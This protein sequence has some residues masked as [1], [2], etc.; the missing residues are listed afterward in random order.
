MKLLIDIGHPAHVHYFRNAATHFIAG[1][2]KVLFTTRDKEVAIALLNFY[3]F[4][5]VNFGRPY[6]TITGKMLGLLLFNYKLLQ[7]AIKFKPDILLSAGSIYAAHV[8]FLIRRHHITLE[9]TFNMEQVRLYLP[10]TSAVLTGACEHISLGS[11]EIRYDSYQEMA[12]LHPK[13]F[14]PD[15]KILDELG[16]QKNE[17]F[18]I[19]RFVSWNASHD[20][21]HGGLNME[22]K[23]ELIGLLSTYGKVFISSEKSLDPE[24][25]KY[26]YPLSPNKMHDALA[27]AD[28]FIGEGATMASECVMLGTPA[29]Y[30]NSIVTHTINEQEKYGLIWHYRCGDGVL[31]KTMELLADQ[32]L[33]VKSQM[34]HKNLLSEK[35]D[36]TA[37]LIWFIENWPESCK[38][39]KN[40]PAIQ[41]RFK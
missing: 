29:I 22:Q 16:I 28:L 38:I 32:Q 12:Y 40:N 5:Y 20:A 18:F 25:E 4:D 17:A 14:T 41:E 26:R 35:I 2:H 21:G 11:K 15:R 36:L 23:R 9:D 27:F 3:R 6:K 30:V 10:F 37:F 1:G 33:K 24:F 8:S 34:G 13:Y 19:L 39:A 7:V 31:A